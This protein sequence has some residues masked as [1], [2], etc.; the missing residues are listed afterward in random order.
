MGEKFR[1]GNHRILHIRK[2]DFIPTQCLEKTA[3]EQGLARTHFAGDHHKPFSAKH[4]IS[5]TG[6]CLC[7]SWRLEKE[8]RI[9]A[10]LERIARQSIKFFVHG[11]SSLKKADTL[12]A[13]VKI[14]I[15]VA[16]QNS[17]RRNRAREPFSAGWSK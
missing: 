2:C 5:Q 11:R 3:Y 9:R 15:T 7:V 4:A 8:I 10:D 16:T 1:H 6:K 17:V 12:P 13:S 14:T